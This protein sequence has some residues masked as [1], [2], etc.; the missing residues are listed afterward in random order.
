MSGK[1]IK[2]RVK[3]KSASFDLAN[4]KV[5]Q[6][7]WGT[8]SIPNDSSGNGWSMVLIRNGEDTYVISFLMPSAPAGNLKE[9]DTV[10]LYRGAQRMVEVGFVGVID[11]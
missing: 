4:F 9:G 10:A 7:L 5:G 1:P 11:D 3:I 2:Y 8:T 6:E